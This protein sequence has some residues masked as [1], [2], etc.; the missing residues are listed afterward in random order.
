MI[1][2][3]EICPVFHNKKNLCHHCILTFLL[4]TFA[5]KMDVVL[6][7]NKLELHSS[8]DALALSSLVQYEPLLLEEKMK[9]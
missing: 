9:M 8:D 2:L 7:L 1:N 3:I 5:L 6:H 4:Q